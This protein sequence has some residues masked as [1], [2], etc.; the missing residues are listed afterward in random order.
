MNIM[1]KYCLSHSHS[2]A[3]KKYSAQFSCSAVTN[4]FDFMLT[5]FKLRRLLTEPPF[6]D[7]W[8]PI[9]H[10]CIIITYKSKRWSF[11]IKNDVYVC[12]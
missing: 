12:S 9:K 3:G 4:H 8:A 7:H 5:E 2:Y 1:L 10:N 6:R 11:I